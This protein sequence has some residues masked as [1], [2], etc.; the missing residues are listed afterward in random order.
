LG[1]NK[2]HIFVFQLF[3]QLVSSNPKSKGENVLMF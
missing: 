3:N 1:K 2:I